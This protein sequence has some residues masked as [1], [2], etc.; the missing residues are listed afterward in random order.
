[1]P[2]R[3]RILVLA[4]AQPRARE[5]LRASLEECELVEVLDW[6][7][8]L[9]HLRADRFDAIVLDPH[10]TSVRERTG[11]LLQSE[12]VLDALAD[13]VAVVGL[14]LRI[15]WANRTFERWCDGPA[16]G[17][18]FYEALG[19]PAI[20]G[21]DRGPTHT[22]LGGQT[23]TKYLERRDG[24]LLELHITPLQDGDARADRM[25]ALCRDVTAD[26]HHQ[27]LLKALQD[28]GRD[29]AALAPDQLAEMSAEERIE[30]LKQNIVRFT[31]DL[32]HYDV[33]ELRMLDRRTGRLEPLL[34]K[35]MTPEEAGQRLT[36][37]PEGNG[38]TGHVAA[39][40]KSYLCPD[41]AADPLYIEGARGMRS[42]LT[43]PLVYQDQV[44]GTFNIESP[45]VGA[46][47]EDDV[48]FAEAFGRAVAEALHTLELLTAEKWEAAT[49]AVE[50]ISREVALPVDDILAAAAAVL[51]RYVGHDAEMADKLKSILSSARQ[52]KR[53]IQTVGE[54]LA[55]A[56]RQ[57]RPAEEAPS[58]EGVRVLVADNDDRV[59]RSAHSILG[60][61]GCIVETA[62]DARE[63]ITM[64][65]LSTY[66]AILADIRLPDLS[67]YEAYGR[68]REAQPQA[69]LVLMT[70]YGYD[71]SHSLVKARQDGLKH[72]LFKPFRIDQLRDAL[73]GCGA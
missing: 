6:S 56:E 34:S 38:I 22:A 2:G 33:I 57:P 35:G 65:R 41:T 60:R 49:H 32:L 54:E 25:I 42:S 55:P 67:G 26:R 51:E 7:Q 16:R 3:P 23:V 19:S 13:A 28:A 12:Q 70:S 52:I 30:L 10:D 11:I 15:L 48:Q 71:P 21:P 31:S 50:A 58:L 17:R 53:C 40:G 37:E 24:R 47:D 66:D 1:M 44:I 4:N 29:L 72:V 59:R 39:V 36:A 46:F 63:A 9:K 64:A 69:R 20:S 45:Q 5:L 8:A 68:L 14:D 18:N 27:Q 73:S 43:V 62:R 61:W